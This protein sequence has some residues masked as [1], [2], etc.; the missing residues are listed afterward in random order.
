[1]EDNAR[2]VLSLTGTD[3]VEFL[4]NLVTNDVSDLDG[5]LVYTAL[6]TPQ[7]KYLA[8]FFV[9]KRG[10]A[11]LL[12]VAMP[13]AAGLAQRLNMY[14]LRADVTIGDSGLKVLQGDGTPPEG[15]LAD[16][17]DTS[18]GWRLYGA[19]GGNQI[20][21]WTAR[22]IA[23]VVPETGVELTPNESYILEQG[24]E[25]LN[26]VDFRKG[27]Y[28]GQE[29]T[30]RMK[31]KTELR[32]GLAQVRIEG[33]AEPGSEITANGKPAGTLHSVA[34]DLGLAYLRFDRAVGEMQAG[35]AKIFRVNASS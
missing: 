7:G 3:V 21:E 12:D 25:R 10:D 19:E 24:F 22:R 16:P 6:L 30:A 13:L 23:A 33:T 8:D 31:H 9:T 20:T 18:L 28:V 34:G 14:K 1:M 26:G 2:T 35:T 5:R 17:R 15:A 32:K 29:V 4:Q 27:C 11:V